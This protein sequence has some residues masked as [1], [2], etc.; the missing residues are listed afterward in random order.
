MKKEDIRKGR[1]YRFIRSMTVAYKKI[2]AYGFSFMYNTVVVEANQLVKAIFGDCLEINGNCVEI[3]DDIARNL[4]MNY[5]D[6]E[7][8]M[9]RDISKSALQ[10]ILSSKRYVNELTRKAKDEEITPAKM[11]ARVAY[12]YAQALLDEIIKRG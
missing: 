6:E 5:T 12:D 11:A 3:T 10:G 4:K 2:D 9:R 7:V 8:Q 1:Y